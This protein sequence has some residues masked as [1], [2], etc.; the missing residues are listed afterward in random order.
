MASRIDP[1][2]N[3]IHA[4]GGTRT[5]VENLSTGV[6]NMDGEAAIGMYLLK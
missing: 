6:I 5:N 1:D 3:P 4:T 2:G